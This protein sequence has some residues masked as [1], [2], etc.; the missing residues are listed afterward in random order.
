MIDYSLAGPSSDAVQIAIY[1]PDWSL[2]N[3]FSSS[4]P[5]K[6][7]D[8][9]TLKI[10]PEW[11]VRQMPP[12]A[13]PGHHRFVW[14][15]HY[16][17]PAG[18]KDENRPDGVWAPPGQY[19]VE[20]TAGG[21]KLRQPLTVIADPRIKVS[22]ADFEAEFRLAKQ[23]EQARLRVRTMLERA[24]DLKS[25]LAKAKGQPG[26]EALSAQ[27]DALVGEG[28]PIGGA[29]PPTTLTSISEW[30][31]NLATAVEGADAAPT[32]DDIRGFERVS[33]ALTAIEPRWTAFEGQA[34]SQLPPA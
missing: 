19:V 4:D 14:D 31:D 25:R 22:Q 7:L 32:P 15:L 34:R 3:R 16:S 30:L 5:V 24:E 17:K 13:T 28:A 27:Y 12:L 23:V 9:S 2:V 26:A 33:G 8:L 20:L 6:P 10:A 29:T 1:A 11:V 18:L 21:Q